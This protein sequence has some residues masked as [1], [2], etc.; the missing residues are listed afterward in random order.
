MRY[1]LGDGGYAL[2]NY[3]TT[4]S[5]V[6]MLFVILQMRFNTLNRA[7]W[8]N[9]I[10]ISLF[11][12]YSVAQLRF[13]KTIARFKRDEII[14]DLPLPTAIC[15]MGV[16]LNL[17]CK[18]YNRSVHLW[19]I[20]HNRTVY[21]VMT[22]LFRLPKYGPNALKPIAAMRSF[23]MFCILHRCYRKTRV[24]HETFV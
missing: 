24:I 11:V 15:E 12:N 13:I 21:N 14:V 22:K 9:Y 19:K 2:H 18:F 4:R 17:T 23:V 10:K 16:E 8:T 3:T 7:L 6:K 20:I 5:V 1:V